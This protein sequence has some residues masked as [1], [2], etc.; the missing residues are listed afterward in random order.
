MLLSLVGAGAQLSQPQQ[1]ATYGQA[2][3]P[4]QVA[5]GASGITAAKLDEAEAYLASGIDD[6]FV[7]NEVA[8]PHKWR[9]TLERCARGDLN[10]HALAGT[11]T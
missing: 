1:G 7:A 2:P 8:G 10:P 3:S 5:A 11:G 4:G 9:S 6:I